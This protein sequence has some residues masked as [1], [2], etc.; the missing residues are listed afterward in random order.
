MIK[1]FILISLLF[2]VFLYCSGVKSDKEVINDIILNVK[3]EINNNNIRILNDIIDETYNDQY[4]RKKYEV[5]NIIKNYLQ[6]YS[7]LKVNIEGIKISIDKSDLAT[8]E[9]SVYFTASASS[10]L[11]KIMRKYT[12]KY[13]FLIDFKKFNNKW[14]VIYSE[15][16]YTGI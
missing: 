9:L 16:E 4:N 3:N 1:N 8:V 11:K 7:G 10:I 15:Y 2:T 5:I 12:D 13:V 6:T 14:K